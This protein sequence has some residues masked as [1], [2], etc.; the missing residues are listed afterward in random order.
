[1]TFAKKHS[2]LKKKHYVKCIFMEKMLALMTKMLISHMLSNTVL[3][4]FI[5]HWTH[6]LHSNFRSFARH[7]F[8]NSEQH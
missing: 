1:M 7:S 8:F 6:S 2:K 3:K 4:Y 5:A